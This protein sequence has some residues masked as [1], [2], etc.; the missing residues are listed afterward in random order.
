MCI[1]CDTLGLEKKLKRTFPSHRLKRGPTP[2]GLPVQ[3]GFT[4]CFQIQCPRPCFLCICRKISFSILVANCR[5][6]IYALKLRINPLPNYN[7]RIRH[8]H[9]KVLDSRASL[10]AYIII[11]FTYPGIHYKYLK[12]RAQNTGK[13]SF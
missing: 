9:S 10:F 12:K 5:V 8:R 13:K 1:L 7:N 4:V 11:V 6:Q 3:S 2:V